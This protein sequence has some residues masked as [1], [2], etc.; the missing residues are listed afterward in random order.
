MKTYNDFFNRAWEYLTKF[1]PAPFSRATGESLDLSIKP[2]VDKTE[3]GH[4]MDALITILIIGRR[5][6]FFSI[7]TDGKGYNAYLLVSEDIAS[8]KKGN[9]KSH[10]KSKK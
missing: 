1:H 10:E 6:G 8:G 4:Y 9:D 5:E 3:W 7:Q 2:T